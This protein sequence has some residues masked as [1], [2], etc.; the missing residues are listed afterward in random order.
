VV[1]NWGGAWKGVGETLCFPVEEGMG[2]PRV[3]QSASPQFD[4]VTKIK[5]FL[6]CPGPD[7]IA[8]WY[9]V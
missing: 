3:F 2:K 1:W 8:E 6:A 7:F 5:T 9:Y 4:F